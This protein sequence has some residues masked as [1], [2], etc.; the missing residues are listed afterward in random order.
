[1]VENCANQDLGLE[2]TLDVSV[3]FLRPVVNTVPS[4]RIRVKLAQD[5]TFEDLIIALCS[6]FGNEILGSIYSTNIIT[7]LNGVSYSSPPNLK[8]L[9]GN[10]KQ[11]EVTFL[12][13]MFGGG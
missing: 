1:L 5:A 9:E 3:T 2:D 13:H 6:C 7:V 4:K 10:Q 12:W 11:A 8:L